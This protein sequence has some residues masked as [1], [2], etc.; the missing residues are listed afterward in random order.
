MKFILYL[1]LISLVVSCATLS[2]EDIPNEDS[3]IDQDPITK[4]LTYDAFG[5]RVDLDREIEEKKIGDS[6]EKIE[7]EYSNV[8][9]YYGN[10]L[11]MDSN[12][13]FYIDVVKLL[14]LDKLDNFTITEITNSKNYNKWVK[15]GNKY[16]RMKYGLINNGLTLTKEEDHVL[17]D[18]TGLKPSTKMTF[19][20]NSIKFG[21]TGMLSAFQNFTVK[22]DDNFLYIQNSF[23]QLPLFVKKHPEAVNIKNERM[24]YKEG[25]KIFYTR[26]DKRH[27]FYTIVRSENSFAY[28][29]NEEN[30]IVIKYLDDTITIKSMGKERKYKVT[31]N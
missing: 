21:S 29:Q 20:D 4:T 9:V 28:L 26:H 8:G 17:A 10:G 25:N 12:L 15:E 16:S 24:L 22:M 1:T 19:T 31:V 5:F 3:L 18:Y 14:E 2:P 7:A 11:F 27:T 13:N 6:I 23:T 30:G